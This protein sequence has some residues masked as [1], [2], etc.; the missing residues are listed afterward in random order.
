MFIQS[1][2]LNTQNIKNV[3][4]TIVIVD[5]DNTL[6]DTNAVFEN[7]QLNMLHCLNKENLNIDPKSEFL[8]LREF[9]DILVEHYNSHEYNFS[10]LALA[11]YLHFKGAKRDEAISKA[12]KAFENKLG[13]EGINLAMKCGNIFEKDLRKFPPLFKDVKKTLK[14]LKQ[15]GCV[16]I[17]SSEGN[18]ERVRRIIK[19]YSMEAYFDHILNGRK[20]I[21]Q[22][23]EAKNIGISIWSIRH[24]DDETIP[25]IV[26]IGDL[27]DRDIRFGNQIGAITVYKPGGYKNH[28]IVKDKDEMPTYKIKEMNEII[29]VLSRSVQK[30]SHIN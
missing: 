13:I 16:I 11:L 24:T 12:C 27:L 19:Y 5:G 4:A 9:D 21:E 6:W 25:K 28:Q 10:V 7:A 22:F 17:L 30:Y 26:V 3:S 20:S 18:K 14:V 2:N 15:H 1:N 23:K 8:T 29:N